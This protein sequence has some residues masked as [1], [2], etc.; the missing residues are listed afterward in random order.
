M[1]SNKTTASV[2]PYLWHEGERAMQEAAGMRAALEQR[3]GA[4]LRDHMRE[5]HR[6]FFAQR[7][8][9]YVSLLDPAGRPWATLLE[10]E[11]G[12]ITSPHPRILAIAALPDVDDPA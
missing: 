2:G 9:I 11:V 5:Q 1:S 4:V 6:E 10:G 7:Q 3:G 8:Q 12:F